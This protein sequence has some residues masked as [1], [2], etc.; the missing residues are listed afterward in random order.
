MEENLTRKVFW[1]QR[2][3][4]RALLG[5]KREALRI[6]FTLENRLS[7]KPTIC[8]NYLKKY[9]TGGGIL[10]KKVADLGKKNKFVKGE[11]VQLSDRFIRSVLTASSYGG[12]DLSIFLQQ[13]YL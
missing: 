5:T 9:K 1:F 3:S 2:L 4:R 8:P 10:Q 7:V 13:F 12:R 11:I 6:S